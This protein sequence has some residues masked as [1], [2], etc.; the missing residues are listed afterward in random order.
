MKML[1]I[2][3]YDATRDIL[4]KRSFT[5]FLSFGLC[6]LSL[7]LL[8]VPGPK[9]GIDFQGGTE[10]ILHFNEVVTD[11]QVREAA[12]SIGLDD[13]TVQRFGSA[14]ERRFLVQTQDVSVVDEIRVTLIQT[15]LEA[16]GD[17]EYAEWNPEQPDR[18]DL[19]F[20]EHKEVDAIEA[21]IF[22][23]GLQQVDIEEVGQ[24]AEARYTLRF[25]DL[26]QIIRAGFGEYFGD[27][28]SPNSGLER[29]ETVGPRAGEQLRTQ[30]IWAMLVALFFILA[31]IWVRFDARYSPGAVA[32]LSHDILI[33]LG[34]F[35][36]L[37]IEIS[38]PI[39]AA[40]LT[41]IGYS[42]NDTIVVFDRI[43]ENLES[44]G[45]RSIEEVANEA[46]NQTM[47]RT[48]ITSIT[49]LIAVGSIAIIAT[50]LIQDFAVALI[51]GIIVGTYSSIFVATPV[52]LKMDEY[53]KE[54][55]K[56]AELL[57]KADEGSPEGEEAW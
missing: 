10:M 30:G 34:L 21:A 32:A 43:R 6:A 11:D 5:K 1:Q 18:M 37:G 9:F 49:T 39:V 53:L 47:S 36:I 45:T 44:A 20:N 7:I 14:A 13:A 46:I 12:N 22:A 2:Y 28:F 57:A 16:L 27:A 31:Y 24:A 15:E 35:V 23:A 4:G 52:M 42:L 54:R 8:I 3:P 26:Q 51:I 55:R 41:I 38:L 17:L 33:A 56:T 48:L 29:L 19:L 40:L 50:G 25:Q